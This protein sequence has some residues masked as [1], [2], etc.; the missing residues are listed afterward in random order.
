MI[1]TAQSLYLWAAFAH[2][3]F[4]QVRSRVGSARIAWLRRSR[5]R[6]P[7]QDW[8]AISPSSRS[9]LYYGLQL[10][11]DRFLMQDPSDTMPSRISDLPIYSF[12]KRFLAQLPHPRIAAV[13]QPMWSCCTAEKYLVRRCPRTQ[14]EK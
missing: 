7:T 4:P 5:T 11:R 1:P 3:I 6:S 2:L 10:S 9:L 8:S 14:H 13:P 12:N